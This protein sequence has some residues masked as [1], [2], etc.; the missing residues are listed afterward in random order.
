MIMLIQKK[1]LRNMKMKLE[2]IL[3]YNNKLNY[4]P[5]DYKVKLKKMI[6]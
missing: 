1:L 5:K 6:S 3:V 2:I 4:M